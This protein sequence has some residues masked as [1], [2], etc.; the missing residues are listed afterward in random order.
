MPSITEFSKLGFCGIVHRS[1]AAGFCKSDGFV[2]GKASASTAIQ[3]ATGEVSPVRWMHSLPSNAFLT[4]FVLFNLSMEMLCWECVRGDGFLLTIF[5]L[6]LL[7]DVLL[8]LLLQ[9]V[10]D[11]LRVLVDLF[12]ICF[13]FSPS[14]VSSLRLDGLTS[15]L[16]LLHGNVFIRPILPASFLCFCFFFSLFLSS[17]LSLVFEVLP[18]L[19]FRVVEV[20]SYSRTCIC[21][22]GGSLL[23]P[24]LVGIL[25]VLAAASM[26]SRCTALHP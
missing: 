5:L 15:S 25:A 22:Q 13:P 24:G 2:Y 18:D 14:L 23:L 1:F 16:G 12:R 6:C 17:L 26:L 9:L 7:H 11:N 10:P 3:D 8:K 4:F 19:S 21:T 20:S